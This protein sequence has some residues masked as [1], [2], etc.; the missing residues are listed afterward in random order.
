MTVRDVVNSYCKRHDL[1]IVDGKIGSNDPAP[2][3]PFIIMDCAQAE[4]SR[5]IKPL[6]MH[7][8]LKWLRTQWLAEYK[9]F[10]QRLFSGLDIDKADFVCDMMDEY[11]SYIEND[12]MIIRVAM[13]NLVKTLE[14]DE[15]KI[16][17][18]LMLCNIFSQVAQLT[19]GLVYKTRKRHEEQCP[20]LLKMRRYSHK[21]M[22][23]VAYLSDDIDPNID[24]PL[25]DAIESYVNK[26]TDWLKSYERIR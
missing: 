19:W 12:M 20:E 7:H 11:T 3:L 23:L 6:H 26:T 14:F 24:K 8:E 2:I 13:M 1:D 21:M 18:S 25:S 9:K 15:Q 16:I 4:F 22:N 10:N 17:S 5:E